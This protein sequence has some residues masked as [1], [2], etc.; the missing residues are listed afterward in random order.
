MTTNDQSADTH[1]LKRNAAQPTIVSSELSIRTAHATH[2]PCTSIPVHCKRPPT[3]PIRFFVSPFGA[4]FRGVRRRPSL[5]Y[6]NFIDTHRNRDCHSNRVG[7]VTAVPGGRELV[8]AK[9]TG[10]WTQ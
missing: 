9:E 1:L 6:P 5:S 2:T 10:E 8:S 3:V 4:G 7:P